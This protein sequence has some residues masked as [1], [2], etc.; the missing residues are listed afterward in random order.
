[1]FNRFKKLN[2]DSRKQAI[3]GITNPKGGCFGGETVKEK[4]TRTLFGS[5][6]TIDNNAPEIKPAAKLGGP[7]QNS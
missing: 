4:F 6:V 1:M 7:G 2:E 5:S 3:D